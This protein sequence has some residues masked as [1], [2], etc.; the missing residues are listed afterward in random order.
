[1]FV[2]TLLLVALHAPCLNPTLALDEPDP[3]GMQQPVAT[4]RLEPQAGAPRVLT[5]L[6]SRA[7]HMMR[8]PLA[9]LVALLPCAIFVLDAPTLPLKI[10]L[11]AVALVGVVLLVGGGVAL[12]AWYINKNGPPRQLNVRV[13][14]NN[15]CR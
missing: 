4:S 9:G 6:T 13:G 1:M 8:M 2:S 15:N 14:C 11:G 10:I 12:A 3:S 7:V 5:A